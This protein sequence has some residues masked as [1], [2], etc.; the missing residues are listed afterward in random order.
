MNTRESLLVGFRSK[1]QKVIINYQNLYVN[2]DVDR[3]DFL[4][5]SV[6]PLNEEIARLTA[7]TVNDQLLEDDM[8]FDKEFMIEVTTISLDTVTDFVKNIKEKI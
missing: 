5:V 8:T 2:S 7:I 1:L 6:H 3:E 4:K